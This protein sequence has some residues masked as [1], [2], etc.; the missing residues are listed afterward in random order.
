MNTLSSYL[1]STIN[2]QDPRGNAFDGQKL[3]LLSPKQGPFKNVWVIQNQEI[4]P[5]EL[6]G[7]SSL[8]HFVNTLG[9]CEN[10]RQ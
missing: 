4:G 6:V 10:C 5:N 9:S 8:Q 7:D 3:A 2:Y 1:L